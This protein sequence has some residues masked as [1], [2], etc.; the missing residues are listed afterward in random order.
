MPAETRL[1]ISQTVNLTET[2]T[3][4]NSHSEVF[5]TLNLPW[6]SCDAFDDLL[7]SAVSHTS[8]EW[9]IVEE[10]VSLSPH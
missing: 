10:R 3:Q 6:F 1:G 2:H 9:R 5:V 4:T 7:T 8:I